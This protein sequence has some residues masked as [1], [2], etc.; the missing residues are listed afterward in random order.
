[1]LP[2]P[3]WRANII[4]IGTTA[5]DTRLAL[6][7]L[8]PVPFAK[9]CFRTIETMPRSAS[10]ASPIPALERAIARPAAIAMKNVPAA[11]SHKIERLSRA[12]RRSAASAAVQNKRAAKTRVTFRSA[13]KWLRFAKKPTASV[14]LVNSKKRRALAGFVPLAESLRRAKALQI[15]PEES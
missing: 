3:N 14:G 2:K 4:A 7:R 5:S 12:F 1:M 15:R 6:K 13:A 8:R 10:I 9:P 11:P